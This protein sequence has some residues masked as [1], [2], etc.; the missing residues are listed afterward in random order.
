[1]ARGDE[2]ESFAGL[3]QAL[4]FCG[5]LSASAAAHERARALDPA[6]VTSVPHT[7]FLLGDY[8]ATLDTYG[9]TRY[10]LDAAAWAAL[11]DPT[12]AATLLRDRLAAGQFSALMGGLMTSL[13]AILEDRPDAAAA[14]MQALPLEREPEVV[15]YLARH[16]ALLD[17][18]DDAVRLLRRARSEGLT[19]SRTLERDGAFATLRT[20][21]LFRDELEECRHLE[22]AAR[23]DL[24]RAAGGSLDAVLRGAARA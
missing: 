2:P 18:A 19:A 21:A 8:Q 5:Q 3:V 16:Y 17:G 20:T 9:G 13:L 15:F 23:R 14:T 10:Y 7:H 22:R 1:V 11:G 6:I 24:D 12:R 4:R